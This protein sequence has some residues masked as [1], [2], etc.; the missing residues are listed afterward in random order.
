MGVRIWGSEGGGGRDGRMDGDRIGFCGIL[1]TEF[2]VVPETRRSDLIAAGSHSSC[3]R[4]LNSVPV[5]P[6]LAC[7]GR[8]CMHACM[9]GGGHDQL[10]PITML[11]DP[12]T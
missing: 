9:A 11:C 3:M 2:P 6:R 7:S 10:L 8:Q 5:C 1:Q 12:V 4:V